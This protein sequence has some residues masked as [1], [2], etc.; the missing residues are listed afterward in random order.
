MSMCHF[1]KSV[2]VLIYLRFL[3]AYLFAS[4]TADRIKKTG[5]EG[6]KQL[7]LEVLKTS[8]SVQTYKKKKSCRVFAPVL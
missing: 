7:F 1:Q 2:A 6:I 5:V 8:L 3:L 4:D